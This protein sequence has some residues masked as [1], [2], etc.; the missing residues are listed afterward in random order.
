MNIQRIVKHLLMTDRQVS[1]ILGRSALN[2][3][4]AAFKASEAEH[5][6]GIRFAV[7]GGLV[8]APWFKGQSARERAIELF[9][10]LRVRIAWHMFGC[11]AP[12]GSQGQQV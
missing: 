2:R 11:G 1:R 9:S 12:A 6:G 7:E 5:V 4:E 3:I 10:Q 8:G